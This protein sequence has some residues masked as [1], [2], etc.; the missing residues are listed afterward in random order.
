MAQMEHIRWSAERLAAGWTEGPRDVA[1]RTNPY[2]VPWGE[3]PDDI[4]ELN[5]GWVRTLPVMLARAGFEI[6]REGSTRAGDKCPL[7]VGVTGH[8]FLAEVE[9][10]SAAVNEVLDRLEQDFPG[11]SLTIVSA[12]A[13][14]ADRLVAERVLDRPRAG[15]IVP[16]PVPQADYINDFASAESTEE[17]MH[18]FER[19]DKVVVMP[20]T[21][22]RDEAYE[23]A[24]YYVLDNCDVLIAVWDGQVEQGR[25]GT[26]DIV[27][28]ARERALPLAWVHAGNR[29]PGTQQPTSLGAEQGTV[30][31]ERFPGQD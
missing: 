15:L 11:R 30:S 6:C 10:I 24:G 2:L 20:K 19:A 13:E 21:S 18:L 31:L 27:Q 5:R 29:I 1:R 23:A 9:K 25:G 7:S 4:K 28:G 8:R 16:L 3:L 17:F 22:T 12:L 26:G 14:G